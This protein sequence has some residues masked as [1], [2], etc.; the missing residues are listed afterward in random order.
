MTPIT[1]C[2]ALAFI[3]A[4]TTL[5]ANAG[6][7]SRELSRAEIVK[8]Y[9][10]QTCSTDKRIVEQAHLDLYKLG[11]EIISDLQSLLAATPNPDETAAI[12][13]AVDRLE[14]SD[15]AVSLSADKKEI[16]PGEKVVFTVTVENKSDHDLNI[17]LGHLHHG[18]SFVTGMGYSVLLQP[19]RD[20]AEHRISP[21]KMNY[22]RNVFGPLRILKTVR[23]RQKRTFE[24]KAEYRL[25]QNVLNYKK[26]GGWEELTIPALAFEV[27]AFEVKAPCSILIR[28]HLSGNPY[29]ESEFSDTVDPAPKPENPDAKDWVHS[30]GLFTNDVELKFTHGE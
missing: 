8:H 29:R 16:K 7:V 24:G 28:A 9:I 2:F 5:P 10:K 15:L 20:P 27:S 13:K 30:G 4:F 26:G 23:A 19:N 17:D 18:N 1:R 14:A 12:K 11:T 3:L 6:E 21:G 22:T 25:A